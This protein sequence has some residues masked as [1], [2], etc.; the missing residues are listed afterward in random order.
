MKKA[1]Q[2]VGFFVFYG[3]N[4]SPIIK[5]IKMKEIKVV[6]LDDNGNPTDKLDTVYVKS[7][8]TSDGQQRTRGVPTYTNS[9][10]EI[11]AAFE[12]E[13]KF[14]RAAV[15]PFLRYRAIE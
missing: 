4:L 3:I 6:V 5:G 7:N 10:G 12:D 14:E 9:K 13:T 8:N 11:L 15:E 1:H 2:K